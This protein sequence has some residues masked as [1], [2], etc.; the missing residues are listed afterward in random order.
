MNLRWDP[1]AIQ[2]LRDIRAYI[3]S[4]SSPTSADRVRRHLQKR[5]ERLRANPNL[6]VASSDREIRILAPIRYPYRIYYTVQ[7]NEIAILHIRHTSRQAPTG[8]GR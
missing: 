3:A 1:R 4:A 6:G 5:A 2:D 8:F 7:S